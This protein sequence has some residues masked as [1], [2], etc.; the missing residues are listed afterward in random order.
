MG[1]V[2]DDRASFGSKPVFVS[3][4][5]KTRHALHRKVERRSGVAGGREEWEQETSQTV[6]D[7]ESTPRRD[8]DLCN[9]RDV[10]HN[11]LW[12]RDSGCN[13]C[14]GIAIHSFG[15]CGNVHFERDWV[16]RHLDHFDSEVMACLVK[17]CMRTGRFDELGVLNAFGFPRPISICLHRHDDAL[18]PPACHCPTAVLIPSKD[19]T[20]H[21]NNLSF[22]LADAR[23]DIRVQWIRYGKLR[24][25]Y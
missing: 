1:P 16:Y 17:C 25:C 12:V 9:G 15:D 5:R 22:H 19:L 24:E 6:V 3:V 7:M 11:T 23:E 4:C 20:T 21:L 13:D 8:C 10:V 14:D 2:Q 18:G